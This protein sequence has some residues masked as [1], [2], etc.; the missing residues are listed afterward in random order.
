MWTWIEAGAAEQDLEFSQTKTRMFLCF[1]ELEN[2]LVPLS[3]P[4]VHGNFSQVHDR[5]H[6][7]HHNTP[8]HQR[9]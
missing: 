9:M 2:K 5:E 4:A 8:V 1:S 6:L 3:P 7:G